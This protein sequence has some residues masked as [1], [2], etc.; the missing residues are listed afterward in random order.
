M[1]GRALSGPRGRDGPQSSPVL[2]FQ[3]S[4]PTN[5]PC[6][7][8]R[9]TERRS[10]PSGQSPPGSSLPRPAHTPQPLGK[11]H[12]GGQCGPWIRQGH[13][14][15]QHVCGPTLPARST[16]RLSDQQARR[17]H[18]PAR[19]TRW[20]PHQGRTSPQGPLLSSHHSPVRV[21]SY[22]NN[23]GGTSPG[24][25]AHTEG[26][27]ERTRPGPAA[28]RGSQGADSAQAPASSDPGV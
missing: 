3:M 10:K 6:V 24:S 1:P 15:V 22:S 20:G 2:S 13:G 9:R 11:P 23:R 19:K 21:I 12:P 28:P 14:H 25:R 26:P 4:L 27:G 8:T 17:I 7:R 18:T 5:K 16:A